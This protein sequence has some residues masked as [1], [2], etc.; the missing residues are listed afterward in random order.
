MHLYFQLLVVM[1][2]ISCYDC[3]IGGN[4]SSDSECNAGNHEVC[5]SGGSTCECDTNYVPDAP[6]GTTCIGICYFS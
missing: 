3:A 2:L 4:C 6:D 5:P 1:S